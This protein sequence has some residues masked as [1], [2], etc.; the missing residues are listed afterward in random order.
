MGFILP[1][2]GGPGDARPVRPA[3]NLFLLA[4]AT[5]APAAAQPQ[6]LGIFG[7]WGAFEGGDRCYAI[8]QPDEA[9]PAEGWPAF[10]SVGH[11]RARAGGGQLHVRLSREKR[12][13]SAVLLRID[14]RSFQLIGGGRDAWASDPRADQEIQAAMRTGIDMI[15]ETRSS[16]GLAVRD[17]YRLRGAATAMDAAAIACARRG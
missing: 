4:A 11:W 6:A 8:T 16:Q 13:G 9:P 5:A 15:V 10:A 7:G 1:T 17:H 2:P 14:G 12:Q 3:R